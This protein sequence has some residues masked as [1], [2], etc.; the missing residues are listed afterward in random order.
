MS[1]LY[2]TSLSAQV[3]TLP[4][5]V[6]DPLALTPEG[7][8]LL[9]H[10]RGDLN[11]DGLPDLAVVWQGTD[12]ALI[13]QGSHDGSNLNLRPLVVYFQQPGGG[14]QLQV[15]VDSLVPRKESPNMDDPFDAIYIT[16]RG[17]LQLQ[18]HLFYSMGSWTT[19]DH[20]Y[21][22]RYQ[23]GRF[24]LIGYGGDEVHRGSGAVTVYSINFSTRKMRITR[25]NLAQEATAT[26]EWKRFELAQL[27]ALSEMG[28]LF[29][30]AF[31]GVYL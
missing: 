19:S 27:K 4:Q 24:E 29:R 8:E 16:E 21:K 5:R 12:P 3:L 13:E 23:R 14:Y 10:T 1:V 9:A 7:W 30:W 22:W 2:G 20:T 18:L 6:A 11:Q 31:M 26:T 17:V 28:Q 15:Q 25:G